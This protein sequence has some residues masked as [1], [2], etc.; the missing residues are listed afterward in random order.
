MVGSDDA[1]E[2]VGNDQADE[3]DRSGDGG[4]GPGEQRSDGEALPHDLSGIDAAARGPGFAVGHHVQD[5]RRTNGSDQR[6][7]PS[8]ILNGCFGASGLTD[9]VNKLDRALRLVGNSGP[10]L[11]HGVD[12]I[13]VVLGNAMRGN[14]RIDG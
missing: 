4:C 12:R 5:A 2:K 11:R 8:G 10:T 14:K 6:G 1:P 3:G 9:V 13:V 7:G